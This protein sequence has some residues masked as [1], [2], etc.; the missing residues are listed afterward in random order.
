MRGKSMSE[1]IQNISS[2]HDDNIIS[3]DNQDILSKLSESI[4]SD[5][6]IK[7]FQSKQAA[8]ANDAKDFAETLE[9]KRADNYHAKGSDTINPS[10][11]SLNKLSG[12]TQ[13]LSNLESLF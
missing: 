13:T 8:S 12:S 1:I 7:E 9:Q 10:V 2:S 11:K 5:D 4:P 3:P 6:P